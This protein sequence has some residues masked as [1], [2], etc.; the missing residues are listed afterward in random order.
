[1]L[2]IVRFAHRVA[3]LLIIAWLASGCDRGTTPAQPAGPAKRQQPVG[4]SNRPAA[5]ATTKPVAAITHAIVISV[6]GLRPDL[7]FRGHADNIMRLMD[8]GAFS[9]W[10]RSAELPLTLPS[11]TSM[12]T[13]VK[14]SRHGIDFNGGEPDIYPAFPTIFEIAHSRG[15]TTALVVGKAKLQVLARP[16]SL[17]WHSIQEMEADGV[18]DEAIRVI[19]EHRPAVMGIHFNDC[20]YAGHA[21]L[22]GSPQQLAAVKT[23]DDAIGRI[24][25]AI[26]QA[27]LTDSTL[28]IVTADHGGSGG[29]H[30]TD[31]PG[32]TIPWIARG[33]GI[34]KNY[35]LERIGFY[36]VH[37]E[38]TFAT[39]SLMLG[40]PMQPDID[41]KAVT[42]MLEQPLS[43]ELLQDLR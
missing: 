41:G 25:T 42:R 34:R 12:F 15:M 31:P 6:D 5:V 27:G 24:F 39:V 21:H 32:S 20:D 1:V 13:G 4:P 17:D 30:G 40:L 35:D 8:N 16:G 36:S 38:D 11:H 23:I 2:P 9:L 3:W 37:V 22:W 29:G 43:D 26:D 7:I 14:P 33:P 18:A 28:I 10:A 19:R